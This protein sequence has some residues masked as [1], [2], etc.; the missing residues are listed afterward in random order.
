MNFA[1]RSNPQ[2]QVVPLSLDT[3]LSG[4]V[5]KLG[6]FRRHQTDEVSVFQGKR[7]MNTQE[8]VERLARIAYLRQG[9]PHGK[10]TS[11]ETTGDCRGQNVELCIEMVVHVL[12]CRAA[13]RADVLVAHRS[14]PAFVEQLNRRSQ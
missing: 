8:N 2:L 9:L 14:I 7:D 5:G 12:A 1:E 11:V 4:V 3:C 6:E 10:V 13:G